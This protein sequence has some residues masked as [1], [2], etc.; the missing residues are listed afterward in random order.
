MKRTKR[1]CDCCNREVYADEMLHCYECG[2]CYC[3]R[4]A[5]RLT[6]CECAGELTYFD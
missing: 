2:K 6:L 5:N 4:C 3:K 1:R